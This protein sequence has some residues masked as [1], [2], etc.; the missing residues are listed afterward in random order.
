M[1]DDK[2]EPANTFR[3]HNVVYD[4]MS[5]DEKKEILEKYHMIGLVH[6]AF[7]GYWLLIPRGG[8]I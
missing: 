4:A 5:S 2:I 1:I 7:D 8:T 6:E 3:I